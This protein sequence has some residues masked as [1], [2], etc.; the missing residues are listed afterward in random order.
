M[1]GRKVFQ[2]LSMATTVVLLS[3]SIAFISQHI[4]VFFKMPQAN[5][6]VYFPSVAIPLK[7]MKNI[8]Y[9]VMFWLQGIGTH[10]YTRINT[11]MLTLIQHA[12]E[13]L[14]PLDHKWHERRR[15]TASGN[16][17]HYHMSKMLPPHK[18]GVRMHSEIAGMVH[19]QRQRKPNCVL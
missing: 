17:A 15:S 18:I 2:S 10:I 19:Q 11:E 12:E 16:Y 5:K 1:P 9:F 6:T 8:F 13:P 14:K 3:S 7:I 4:F